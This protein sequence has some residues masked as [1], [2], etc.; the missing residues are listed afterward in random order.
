MDTKVPNEEQ[1]SHLLSPEHYSG[2]METHGNP[3]HL[4][5]SVLVVQYTMPK[6]GPL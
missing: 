6:T 4:N 2:Y 3:L 1:R 5:D